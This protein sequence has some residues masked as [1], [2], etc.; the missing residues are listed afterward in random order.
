VP[1]PHAFQQ[2]GGA[3]LQLA[4]LHAPDQ[5]L[6]VEGHHQ[7]GLVAAVGDTLAADADANAAGPGHAA[8]RRLDLGRDD[9]GGPDAVAHARGNRGQALAAAL[10]A[11]AGVADDFDDVLVQQGGLWRWQRRHVRGSGWCSW[12]CR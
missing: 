4:G 1:A 2:D 9:L 7:V 5:H 6:F 10:R 11:F 12:R 8:C 3:G